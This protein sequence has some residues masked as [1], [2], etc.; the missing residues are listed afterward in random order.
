VSVTIFT[1]TTIVP[2]TGAEPIEGSVVVEDGVIREVTAGGAGAVTGDVVDCRGR[3]LM[4]GLIDAHVH[5]SSLDVEIPRQRR[6]YPTSLLAFAIGRVIRETLDQGYTT[7]RDAGGADWGMKEAVARGLLAGPRMF[8]SGRPLSQTGGHG[9]GRARAEDDEGCGCGAHIGMVHHI[10]DGPDAVLRAAREELRRGADAIKVMAGGGVASPTDSLESI[11]YTPEELRAAVTAAEGAGTYVLAHAYTPT[12][13]RNAVEAGVRSIEHGNFLDPVTADLMAQRGTYLVP[14]FVAYEKLH[15]EGRQ[16]GFAPDKLDK[17]DRVLGEGLDS[18]KRA[19]DAGVAI[20][21]GS[22]LLGPLARHKTRE[23][24]IKAKVLGNHETLIATTRTNAELL[25][26]AGEVGT[27]EPGK[28]ADL[29]LVDG[30]PLT[31]IS[32]L[33]DRDRL[34]AIVVGG[35]FH[36]RRI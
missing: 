20:G 14:T 33:Q 7:V 35:R 11:Q 26:I 13:I 8:V 30:D 32:V 12:A 34:H 16:H 25:G 17:L 3:T 28:R 5:V 18:L 4:P 10:A 6:E 15:E 23:L 29:L 22:D 36:T 21:S 1:N 2:C 9:D 19:K 24:A 31:D 27:I